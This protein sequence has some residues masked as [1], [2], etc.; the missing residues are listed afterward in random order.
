MEAKEKNASD[1][2]VFYIDCSA[3]TDADSDSCFM[4]DFEYDGSDY[5]DLEVEF[6]S[7]RNE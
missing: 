3:V 1:G 4:S 5:E 7:E 2:L 6:P